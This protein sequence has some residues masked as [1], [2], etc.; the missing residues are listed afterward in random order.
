M[1]AA[2][3]LSTFTND[4]LTFDVID[5]GP[6]DG[7]V[8][9]ALHGFP[10]RADSWSGVIPILTAAGFRVLAP[11]QRGYS[12]R[13]R[14]QGIRNYSI[15]RLSADVLA[16]AKQAKAPKFH[17]LGHDWGAAVAWHLA[18]NHIENVLSVSA[19]S[20]P[21]MQALL[22]ALPRGQALLSW[23]MGFFQIPKLPEWIVRVH[24]GWVIRKVLGPYADMSEA[25]IE[26][27]VM[28]S[29]EPGAIT[30]A[31]N[32]Y[33]ALRF[34]AF[35][36][37]A[38]IRVPALFIWGDRDSAMGRTAAIGAGRFIDGPYRF[39]ILDGASHWLSEERPAEIAEL[40]LEHVRQHP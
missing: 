2:T 14:P 36:K 19:L 24:N 21:P 27:T 10:E 39:E 7:P 11:D 30:A 3:R 28:L 16:L 37:S 4:G 40:V 18:G 13:A 17:V 35:A 1:S 20:V 38:R 25:M 23:Y 33:R 31:M 5:E 34:W 6:L 22:R 12:T 15:D 32:W 29:K 9:V 26:K 8:I